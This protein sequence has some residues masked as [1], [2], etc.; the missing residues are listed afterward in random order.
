MKGE[1]NSRGKEKSA[2]ANANSADGIYR[3]KILD[4]QPIYGQFILLPKEANPLKIA[5]GILSKIK[6]R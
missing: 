4:A 6:I 5:A 2:D 3:F 1:T